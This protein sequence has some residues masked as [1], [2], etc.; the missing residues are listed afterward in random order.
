MSIKLNTTDTDITVYDKVNLNHATGKDVVPLITSIRGDFKELLIN[1]FGH[2][3]NLI[4]SE[5]TLYKVIV[6]LLGEV[7]K[8]DTIIYKSLNINSII[9]AVA[10]D[11][12]MSSITYR[13]AAEKLI[14]KG[15]IKYI[16]KDDQIVLVDHFNVNTI[17][18]NAKYMVIEVKPKV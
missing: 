4:D 5:I 7:D 3:L 1:M 9:K 16:N 2:S 17:Y 14:I 11:T 12:N 10:K 15:V 13:R 18:N 6:R 8:H